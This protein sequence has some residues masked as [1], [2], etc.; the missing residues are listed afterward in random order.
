MKIL[1]SKNQG[2][3][4]IERLVGPDCPGHRERRFGTI[5]RQSG[6]KYP[7]LKNALGFKKR[8]TLLFKHIENPA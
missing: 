6:L 8:S 7:G 4:M 1:A 2:F 5:L 3:T